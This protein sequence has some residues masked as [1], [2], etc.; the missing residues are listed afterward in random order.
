MGG[1]WIMFG[2][3]PLQHLM[4]PIQIGASHPATDKIA[5]ALSARPATI[6]AQAAVMDWPA[7]MGGELVTLRAGTN[8]WTCLPDDP[9]TPTDDPMCLDKMWMNWLK[10]SMTG[11]KPTITEVGIAYMLQ[12]GSVADNDNPR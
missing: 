1:P 6:T 3:T 10:A 12:G 5:N 4:V 9:T 11:T 2:G 7:T 8:G